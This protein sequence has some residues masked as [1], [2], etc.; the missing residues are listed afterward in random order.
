RCGRPRAR[1]RAVL[2]H[3]G[4]RRGN[5]TGARHRPAHRRGPPS[6]LAA[7]GLEA[8]SHRVHGADPSARRVRHHRSVRRWVARAL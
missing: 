5:G 7:G 3:Q 1:V 8:R 6:R 4:G 2:H